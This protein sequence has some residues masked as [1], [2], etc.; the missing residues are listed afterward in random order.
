[1]SGFSRSY[2]RT[3]ARLL[4]FARPLINHVLSNKNRH[5]FGLDRMVFSSVF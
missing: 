2:S 3:E 4:V 1:M 5:S